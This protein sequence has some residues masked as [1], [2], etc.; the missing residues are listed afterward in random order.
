MSS[1]TDL[2]ENEANYFLW[3]L[4]NLYKTNP[5]ENGGCFLDKSLNNDT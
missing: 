2:E 1:Q 3:N 5:R 4:V